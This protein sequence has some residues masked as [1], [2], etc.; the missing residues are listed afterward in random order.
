MRIITFACLSFLIAMTISLSRAAESKVHLHGT[1]YKVSCV[2]NNIQ[3]IVFGKVGVKKVDGIRYL[4]P[5]DFS[6]TCD[7]Q[8]DA[9]LNLRVNGNISDFNDSAV[10]TD[11]DGLA[12]EIKNNGQKIKIGDPLPSPDTAQLTAVP[13]QR[14]G[15]ALSEGHFSAV[16]TLIVSED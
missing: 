8:T 7:A 3:P 10:Q 14:P 11:V 15:T 9:T 12:I 16:A 2:V 6:Y 5:V 13:V 1:L 4:M